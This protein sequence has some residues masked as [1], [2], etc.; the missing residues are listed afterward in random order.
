MND[1][2]QARLETARAIQTHSVIPVAPL[3]QQKCASNECVQRH[4][5]FL[6]TNV[7]G[8]TESTVP[9]SVPQALQSEGQPLD[10]GVR[11]RMESRFGHDFGQVRVHA[12]AAA[13]ESARSVD[14]LAYTFGKDVVFARGQY[15]PHT[16]VGQKLLAHELAHVIQ[17]SSAA[18]ATTP[19]M[20]SGPNDPLEQAAD[21]FAEKVMSNR[22]APVTPLLRPALSPLPALQRY[23]VPGGLACSEVVDW[24]DSNSPYKPEWAET[25]CTYSFNGGL[26]VSSENVAGGVKL[27]AKG[28]SKL[29]VGVSCPVDRP[30][31]SPSRR[32]NRDAEVTAWRN[33]RSALD[34]HENEHRKI[35]REWKDTLEG[36]FRAVDVTVTGTDAADARQ[37]LVDKVQADQQSWTADAQAAQDAIDPYRGA[38]LT[39][40]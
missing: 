32:A 18:R 16:T 20:D 13:A 17:Q 7:I 2:V 25:R 31:W 30:E 24:L 6:Q 3:L 1:R 8:S 34:A 23:R 37:Q 4:G 15:A 36:R 26:T 11:G 10:A 39:C 35:G 40:P 33:M 29:T 12:D 19:A 28:H 27:R 21:D 9:A 5:R 14:A 38:V 22:D